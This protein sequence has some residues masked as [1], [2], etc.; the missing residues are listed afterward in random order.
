MAARTRSARWPPRSRCLR[1][2]SSKRSGC[3]LNKQRRSRAGSCSAGGNV[4]DGRCFRRGGR[5]HR[6][7][8]LLDVDRARSRRGGAHVDRGTGPVLKRQGRHGLRFSL[9]ERRVGG[10]CERANGVVDQRDRPSG[11]EKSARIASEAV[12][13]AQRTNDRVNALSQAANRIGDVAEIISTIASQT[14][15]LALNATIEAARAGE[16]GRGFAVVASEVKALADQT[17]KATGE[18][19]L[20]ISNIQSATQSRL[21]PSVKSAEL[22]AGSPTYPRPS[23]MPSSSRV[24]RRGRSRAT[25]NRRRAAR[26]WLRPTSPTCSAAPA[27]PVRHRRKC[28]RRPGRCRLKAIGCSTKSGSSSKLCGRRKIESAQ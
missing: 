4:Q 16:A 2:T 19:G 23:P 14:N 25:Y 5:Q 26:R 7:R 24:P 28:C 8:C 9:G 27:K 1:T 20:Q 17:A 11:P 10:V 3:A 18:I 21:L 6:R 12:L 13:Q 15:L 22:S